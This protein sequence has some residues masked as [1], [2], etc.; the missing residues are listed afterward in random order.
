MTST[1][2]KAMVISLSLT[3]ANVPPNAKFREEEAYTVSSILQT[4]KNLDFILVIS[5][6]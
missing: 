3:P 2:P 1:E 5:D 4:Q 6:D